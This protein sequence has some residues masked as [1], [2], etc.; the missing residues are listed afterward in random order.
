MLILALM[1]CLP[2]QGAWVVAV[3][4]VVMFAVGWLSVDINIKAKTTIQLFVDPDY[5]GKVLGISTSISFILIPLSLVIAGGMTEILPAFVLP[6]LNGIVLIIVLGIL[7]FAEYK[8]GS[9]VTDHS[10]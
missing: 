6:M 1:A 3:L 8:A 4:C 2:Y 7:W 10:L 5:L 9:E